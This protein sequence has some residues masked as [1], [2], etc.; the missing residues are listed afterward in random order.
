M[1]F[2]KAALKKRV[3]DLYASAPLKVETLPPAPGFP[4]GAAMV[5]PV[6]TKDVEALV[7]W[8]N[9]KDVALYPV[10]SST[11]ISC[12]PPAA[13]PRPLVI[14]NMARNNRL[15]HADEENRIAV[16]EAGVT[17][18]EIDGLLRPYGLR[19]FKPLLPQAQKSVLASYLDREPITS[20][21]NQW[22]SS[23]P[24]AALEVVFGCGER[25]R[26]GGGAAPGELE[27]NLKSGLRQ[28]ISSGPQVTDF[29]RVLQG[30]QGSLG[31]VSWGSAYCEPIP[32]MER[33]VL[34]GSD[35]LA[36]LV[37][38]AY[39]TTWRR[40]SCQILIVNARHLDLMGS[41]IAKGGAFT[42]DRAS[43]WHL[44][45][46]ITS[47]PYFPEESLSVAIADFT[48]DA[49]GQGLTVSESLNG[50]SGAELQSLLHSTSRQDYKAARGAYENLFCLSQLDKVDALLGGADDRNLPAIYIQPMIHG[51]CCHV[52]AIFT[53][54]QFGDR[55]REKR[56]EVAEGWAQR[57]AFFSRPYDSW[58]KLAFKADPGA[59]K[60]IG[61]IKSVLDP[62]DIMTP[63]RFS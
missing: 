42:G 8:A 46:N 1:A 21:Y 49:E 61:E 28:M 58:G 53:D 51:V 45:C 52:E 5:F 18:G 39:R 12:P 25:F 22:D 38:L 56:D 23:D 33:M 47:S 40:T 37:E 16:I 55:R 7:R 3:P 9:E 15:I 20:P 48:S 31:I 19:A 26:T 36:P 27:D 24:L 30:S 6:G 2:I 29:T 63:G 11:P 32:A 50:L 41:V 43:N 13:D 4:N 35:R 57:G 44:L 60:S 14:V 17:F 10:S 34:V 59:L 62:R 54:A